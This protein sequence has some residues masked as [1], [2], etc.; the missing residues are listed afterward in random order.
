[1]ATYLEIADLLESDPFRRR[2]NVAV[3]IA[4]RDILADPQAVPNDK[5]VARRILADGLG[6]DEMKRTVVSACIDAAVISAG[7]AV[8]DA[9]LQTLVTAI[10]K[11]L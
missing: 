9:V 7:A 11:K 8:A 4:A 2:V 3:R 1:M 5:V 10:V 6:A